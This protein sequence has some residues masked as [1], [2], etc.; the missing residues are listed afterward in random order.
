MMLSRSTA[1]SIANMPSKW[2]ISCWSNSERAWSM[3]S[4]VFSSPSMV[5]YLIEIDL[6][7]L[8]F[9]KSQGKLMQSSHI[10]KVS[11]EKWVMRGLTMVNE[12]KGE[13][14]PKSKE[15][16]LL[17]MPICGADTALPNPSFERNLCN[18]W[19][20]TETS[21]LNSSS[22]V[23]S[24]SIDTCLNLGSPLIELSC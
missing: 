12:P 23:S 6:L 24:T 14:W 20:S 17:L 22:V 11:S 21:F 1:L 15:M 10:V 13:D 5:V 7:R 4:K 18:T 16:N 19:A 3:F 2:S 8:T 9:T